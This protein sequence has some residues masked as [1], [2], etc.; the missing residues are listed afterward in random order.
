MENTSYLQNCL[1]ILPLYAYSQKHSY[2]PTLTFIY[3]LDSDFYLYLERIMDILTSS[4]KK[5]FYYNH[6]KIRYRQVK[7]ILL[8]KVARTKKQ[9][10]FCNACVR[11]ISCKHCSNGTKGLVSS[12][13]SATTR[14]AKVLKEPSTNILKV[15]LIFILT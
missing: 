1:D 5:G 15:K 2:I 8:T 3:T 6:F 4:Y 13:F 10:Q 12:V 14:G 7:T 11:N 9:C